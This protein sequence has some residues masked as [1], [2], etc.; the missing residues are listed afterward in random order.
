MAD[1]VDERAHGYEAPGPHGGWVVGRVLALPDGAP[2][3]DAGR[4]VPEGR[5][6]SFA[7]RRR[8]ASSGEAAL[9]LR[10]D[11]GA[12]GS[13][14]VTVERDGAPS[15]RVEAAVLPARAATAGT[16][17]ASRSGDVRGGDRVRDLRG[18]RRASRLPRLA[19]PA[20]LPASANSAYAPGCSAVS[21]RPRGKAV[22]LARRMRE[23]GRGA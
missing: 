7:I 17:S 6:E 20:G 5:R 10:T 8:R 19:G 13:V 22:S 3:F 15:S 14:R 16:R 21:G 4:I 11:G 23:D 2:R 18:A 9:V 12:E 1:L